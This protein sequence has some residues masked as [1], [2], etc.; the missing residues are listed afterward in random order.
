M[1]S[2]KRPWP[3]SGRR[4]RQRSCRDRIKECPDDNALL[5][6]LPARFPLAQ[7]RHDV[8]ARRRAFFVSVPAWSAPFDIEID[9]A[10][11]L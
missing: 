6:S 7:L 10:T 4:L 8:A 2:T 11:A 1:V 5:G 3:P 9:C